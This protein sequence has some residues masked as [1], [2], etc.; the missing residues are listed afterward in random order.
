VLFQLYALKAVIQGMLYRIKQMVERRASGV[1]EETSQAKQDGRSK[2]LVTC[3][4]P[5]IAAAIE[6]LTKVLI[7]ATV[8]APVKCC[9]L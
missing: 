4:V 6:C 1:L 2:I 7:P 3:L 9:Y 8:Q 5:L